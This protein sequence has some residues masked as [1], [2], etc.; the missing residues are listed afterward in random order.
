MYEWLGFF[1]VALLTFGVAFALTRNPPLDRFRGIVIA[2]AL[3]RLLG[4]TLRYEVISQLYDGVGDAT[5]YYEYGRRYAPY[6]HRL[7]FRFLS[8][9]GNG[10]WWGTTFV[11]WVSAFVVAIVG[12]SE[13]AGFLAFSLLS[14]VGLALAARAFLRALPRQRR[15]LILY[16][17]FFA[18]SLWFWPSSMGKEALVIFAAGV[19]F[20]GYV[21]DGQ[22]ARWPLLLA[23]TAGMFA[24][25]PHV[26]AVTLVAAALAP[27]VAG[28]TRW[29]I[30]RV[31]RAVVLAA[32]AL[33]VL[34][35]SVRSLGVEHP[36]LE[37]AREFQQS[38]AAN[39][40]QGGSKIGPSGTGLTALAFG[41]V[42]VLLRPFPW[43]AHNGQALLSAMEVVVV[44]AVILFRRRELRAIRVL[45]RRHWMLRFSALFVLLY[46][47]LI[48]ATMFNLGIVARQRTL[49][50]PFLFVFVEGA[51]VLSRARRTV[52]RPV[53]VRV[54]V[55]PTSRPPRSVAC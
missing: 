44:W 45:W 39:T 8:Q 23:G 42:N 32:V 51:A 4:A 28:P 34:V 12:P 37:G 2:A 53:V 3:F 43:E 5:S 15:P 1:L 7:D 46:A 17:L 13:R 22:Q 20:A 24:V 47:G 31:A 38:R 19:F 26:A 40:S 33:A 35:F 29:T 30:G 52:R 18:P 50:W 48:G 55:A 36:D 11:E 21:G 9:N 41:Y 10:R 16:W 27:W 25:R 49:M 54:A 6:I 14:F